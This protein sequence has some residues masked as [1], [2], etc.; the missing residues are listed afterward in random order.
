MTGLKASTLFR[1]YGKAKD[2]LWVCD[3][4]SAEWARALRQVNYFERKLTL[5][6]EAMEKELEELRSENESLASEFL[7]W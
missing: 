1:A 7:D 4:N 2:S 3:I 6:L 5:K